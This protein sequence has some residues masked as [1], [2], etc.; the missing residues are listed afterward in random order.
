MEDK[1]ERN[2]AVRLLGPIF[3]VDG[4]D[5]KSFL[6]SQS[7]TFRGLSVHFFCCWGIR[8]GIFLGVLEMRWR[9]ELTQKREIRAHKHWVRNLSVHVM[10]SIH[11]VYLDTFSSWLVLVPRFSSSLVS[12]RQT[13]LSQYSNKNTQW[14]ILSKS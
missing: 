14:Q 12:E 11:D 9:G 10:L 1:M 8:W 7:W 5:D 13:C 2:R 4:G 3:I 6:F